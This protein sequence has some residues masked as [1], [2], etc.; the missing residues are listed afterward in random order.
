MAHAL[1]LV[2]SFL[3]SANLALIG[4]GLAVGCSKEKFSG[5]VEEMKPIANKVI[6]GLE[7][8]SEG[9]A[10]TLCCNILLPCLNMCPLKYS[11]SECKALNFSLYQLLF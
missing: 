10:W 5:Y 6:S 9:E 1:G 11:I 3:R 2:K 4:D 7:Q 8:S